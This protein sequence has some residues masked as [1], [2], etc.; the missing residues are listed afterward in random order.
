MCYS[1]KYLPLWGGATSGV[2]I[3][4]PILPTSLTGITNV[5]LHQEWFTYCIQNRQYCIYNKFKH[6]NTNNRIQIR[7]LNFSFTNQSCSHLRVRACQSIQK[8]R[9]LKK[10]IIKCLK[11]KPPFILGL[12]YHLPRKNL[13]HTC[14]PRLDAS[15]AKYTIVDNSIMFNDFK[16]VP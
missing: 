7:S 1:P 8:T 15:I 3:A 16:E 12:P 9:Q 6:S 13:L 2:L 4:A 5:I 11:A 10:N 14:P